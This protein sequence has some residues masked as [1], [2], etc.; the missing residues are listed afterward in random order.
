MK[1]KSMILGQCVSVFGAMVTTNIHL[2]IFS[3][4]HAINISSLNI[5]Q[6]RRGPAVGGLEIQAGAEPD[7]C[8][9]SIPRIEAQY[10]SK[11]FTYNLT[12]SSLVL[13]PNF[14]EIPNIKYLD[15][16]WR[17]MC[18]CVGGHVIIR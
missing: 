3:T 12:L 13:F 16:K 2:L 11:A 15:G 6:N 10:K 17:K 9:H 1:N 14:G 4:V 5:A 18:V 7:M 8:H